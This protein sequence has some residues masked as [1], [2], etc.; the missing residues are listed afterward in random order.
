MYLFLWETPEGERKWEAVKKNQ[1]MGFLEKIITAGV[2]PA[3]VMVEFN[4]LLMH[5]VWQEYHNG[6]S[7]VTFRKVNKEIYGTAPVESK[8]KPL[9]V[10]VNKEKPVFKWGWLAPDGRFFRCDYGG[11]SHLADKICGEIQYIANPER[12]LEEMGWAKILSGTCTGKRYAVGMGLEKKLS[13]AQ[14]KTLQEMGTD[15]IYGI[16]FLL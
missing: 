1:T 9:Q 3:T 15:D 5:W 10:P 2:H 14:L 6:C 4:P 12:H 16:S 7:D 11:H 13:D 8:H